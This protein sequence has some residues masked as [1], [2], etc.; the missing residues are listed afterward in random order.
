[1]PISSA[2]RVLFSRFFAL[3]LLLG[4]LLGVSPQAFAMPQPVAVFKSSILKRA[5]LRR[6]EP[7]TPTVAMTTTLAPI[8]RTGL[9]VPISDNV[10]LTD[11][12]SVAS[13][14]TL[15]DMDVQLTG[16][17]S[18]VGDMVMTLTQQSVGSRIVLLNRPGFPA[19]PNGCE[20][21]DFSVTLDD[22]GPDGFVENQCFSTTPALRNKPRPAAPLN[23][24]DGLPLSS[25]WALTIRDTQGGDTG[26]LQA[27]CLIP[28]ILTT[29][30]ATTPT[31]ALSPTALALALGPN[32]I[33][34]QTLTIANPGSAPL[35][36]QVGE[37]HPS[38]PMNVLLYD[39][40]PLLNSP[41]TGANGASES[42][43]QTGLGLATLGFDHNQPTNRS[44]ADDFAVSAAGGWRVNQ[45]AFWMYEEN[46]GITSSIS[47]T[48]YRV[49][50]GSP[51]GGGSIIYGDLTTNRL[52]SASFANLYRAL[53]TSTTN[54]QRAVM[55]VVASGTTT[56]TLP[57]GTYWLDWAADGSPSFPGPFI[58]PMTRN[59][60]PLTGNALTRTNTTWLPAF[61]A[62]TNTQQGFPFQLYGY[63]LSARCTN[64][65]DMPWLT[66][67][68][69][70]SGSV[71]SGA[72]AALSVGFNT[73]G[74]T[75]GNTYTGTLCFLSNDPA[76]QL[77][78]VPV[79]LTVVNLPPALGLNTTSFTV[80]QS[81]NTTGTRA[82]QISNTGGNTLTWSLGEAYGT[83]SDPAYAALNLSTD[84]EKTGTRPSVVPAP[85]VGSTPGVG[86]TPLSPAPLLPTSLALSSAPP[87]LF[88]YPPAPQTPQLWLSEDFTSVANLPTN[89]WAMLNRS[90]PLGS[91]GWIQGN[92]TS[93]SAHTGAPNAYI[94]ANYNNTA[95]NG[96]ISN[97]LLT[98][99]LALR[100][101][102]VL[103]FYTRVPEDTTYADRLEVRLSVSGALTD[104]G[105]TA[106]DVGVFT[107]T[108]VTINPSLVITG[109]PLSWAAYTIAITNVA[110]PTTGRIAFRYYVT[111]GGSSGNNSNYIGIDTVRYT[112]PADCT[113]PLDMPWLTLSPAS[114][115]TLSG[116]PSNVTLTFNTAN[117]L[118][119]Q[120]YT[121]KLCLVSN[122]SLNALAQIPVALTSAR[123]HYLPL[124]GK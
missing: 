27:W 19:N 31:L 26:V 78:E 7:N 77:T 11:T 124:V 121:G 118:F 114:G 117:L 49:W 23:L 65:T 81:P 18:F 85:S 66:L 105:T 52:V 84:P 110:T 99:E 50:N 100:N 20:H 24:F 60:L 122:D 123:L 59:G 108:L 103:T 79:T 47:S 91:A 55:R 63:P 101:G 86:S 115:N 29:T 58:P 80:F 42:L 22:E 44:V 89:G 37:G 95:G 119:G 3:W 43:V 75:I 32:A 111:E 74:L 116:V 40:G 96:T 97:W 113:S 4:S 90:E 94:G 16:T 36:A 54:A 69:Q 112:P 28:T 34:T 76:R 6:T 13:V 12:L 88:D 61:D 9:T 33:Q 1:M 14:G 51:T 57:A 10:T 38:N 109:Y 48:V 21:N 64:P 45:L 62:G 17:H 8:C 35:L 39:S 93:F 5:L 25:T 72:N 107:H 15:V 98:P 73:A 46:S 104:V 41:G 53:D 56:L 30:T 87:P 82:L 92:A 70:V 67:S 83:T 71:A 68:G 2:R 102:A 120:R 106:S